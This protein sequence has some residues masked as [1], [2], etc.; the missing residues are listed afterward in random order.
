MGTKEQSQTNFQE[1]TIIGEAKVINYR[2]PGEEWFDIIHV[3]KNHYI[4]TPCRVV[5]WIPNKDGP[6]YREYETKESLEIPWEYVREY[7]PK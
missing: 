5:Y 7:H 4:T 1:Q 2:K 6:G 3:K